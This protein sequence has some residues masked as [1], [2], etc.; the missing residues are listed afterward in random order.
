MPLSAA[1]RH[2]E[3]EKKVG[4]VTDCKYHNLEF[5]SRNFN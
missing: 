4:N 5:Q 3:T 1:D 2:S